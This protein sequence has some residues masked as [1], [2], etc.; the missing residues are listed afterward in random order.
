M[1]T[2]KCLG[3]LIRHFDS[4]IKHQ[5]NPYDPSCEQEFEMAVG[6]LSDMPDLGIEDGYLNLS[7]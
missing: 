1:L 7:K 5:Y 4:T 2:D 6:G 3:D